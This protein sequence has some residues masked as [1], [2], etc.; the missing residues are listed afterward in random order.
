MSLPWQELRGEYARLI[1]DDVAH[2]RVP[3]VCG[4]AKL[5]QIDPHAALGLLEDSGF[6]SLVEVLADGAKTAA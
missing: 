2:D 1:A 3:R 5:L 4:H 6:Y